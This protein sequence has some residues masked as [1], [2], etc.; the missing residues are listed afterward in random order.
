LKKL[1]A[2]FAIDYTKENYEELAEK[3]DVVYDAVG[4]TFVLNLNL[5]VLSD[6]EVVNSKHHVKFIHTTVK[7]LSENVKPNI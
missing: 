1:G 2:D 4:K 6:D 5:Y 3:F 7:F